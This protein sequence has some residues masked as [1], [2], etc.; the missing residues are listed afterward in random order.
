MSCPSSQTVEA[1][2]LLSQVILGKMFKITA[3]DKRYQCT[4]C[5]VI[6]FSL[7]DGTD[8]EYKPHFSLQQFSPLQ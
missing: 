3:E 2:Y 5:V 8:L 6:I 7:R 1:T 4:K